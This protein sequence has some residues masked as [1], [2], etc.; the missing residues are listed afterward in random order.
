MRL[1]L[2][3][4]QAHEAPCTCLLDLLPECV[5][6]DRV[7]IPMLVIF[8][9]LV[10]FGKIYVIADLWAATH[11]QLRVKDRA[12]WNKDKIGCNQCLFATLEV[13]EPTLCAAQSS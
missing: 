5:I 1:F 8:T 9:R 11:L 4:V 13:L 3:C 2:L 7:V 12:C 10:C 6:V